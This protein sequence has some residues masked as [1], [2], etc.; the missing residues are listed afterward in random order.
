M[1]DGTLASSGRRTELRTKLRTNAKQK[2]KDT[3]TE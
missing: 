1:K 3:R 2:N